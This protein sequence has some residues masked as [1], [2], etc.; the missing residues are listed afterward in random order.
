VNINALSLKQTAD[1][2]TAGTKHV[3][4]KGS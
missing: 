3:L 2:R 1:P 4:L